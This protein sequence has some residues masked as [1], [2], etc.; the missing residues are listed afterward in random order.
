MNKER[1]F[2]YIENNQTKYTTDKDEAA[3]K[4]IQG[5]EVIEINKEEY[6]KRKEDNRVRLVPESKKTR[7]RKKSK[8]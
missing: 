1:F 3:V 2:K 7:R 8:T 4:Q 5:Y 6:D